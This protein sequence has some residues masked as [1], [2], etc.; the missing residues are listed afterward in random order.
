MERMR[1]RVEWTSEFLP[2]QCS[3]HCAQKCPRPIEHDTVRSGLPGPKFV[4]PGRTGPGNRPALSAACFNDRKLKLDILTCKLDVRFPVSQST[5]YHCETEY[6]VWK[7]QEIQPRLQ[8]RKGDPLSQIEWRRIFLDEAHTIRNSR[9]DK[10]KACI[11]LRAR[12]RWCVT[13][14]PINNAVSDLYSLFK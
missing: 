6:F 5:G 10:A 2:S 13:G 11:Q 4:V 12:Y 3:C 7:V 1:T 9:R 14:T 8:V